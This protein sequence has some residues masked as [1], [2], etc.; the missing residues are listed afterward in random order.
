VVAKTSAPVL[1]VET[2]TAWEGN[3]SHVRLACV[4]SDACLPFIVAVRRGQ[5][6]DS[7]V[8]S[9]PAYSHALKQAP[10]EPPTSKIAVRIGSTAILLLDG[11]H[12]HIRVPVVCLENGFVGQTI[13]VTGKGRE[14]TYLAVVGGDGLLRG[15]L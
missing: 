8:L 11:S 7:V 10:V 14:L 12:V 13:H 4:P 9:A 5:K 3:Q 15:R 6:S 1:R 2:V